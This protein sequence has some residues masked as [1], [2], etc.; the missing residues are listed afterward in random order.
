[1]LMGMLVDVLGLGAVDEA[2][3]PPLISE[4]SA[5]DASWFASV[6]SSTERGTN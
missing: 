4:N 1:M 5:R 2:V 6:I 3:V